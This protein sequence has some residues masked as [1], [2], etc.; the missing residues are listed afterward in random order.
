MKRNLISSLFSGL[1]LAA[2]PAGAAV[3]NITAVDL[4]GCDVLTISSIP[5]ADELGDPI[6]GFPVGERISH[7][8]STV[9]ITV[10]FDPAGMGNNP[11]IN[12]R[13][14]TITNLEA[15]SFADVYYVINGGF[16]PGTFGNFDGLVNG[17]QAMKID[18]VG[19]NR[20]LIS[21]SGNAD[22]IFQPGETWRFVV[23]DYQSGP[24][25][26]AFYTPG[27]VGAGDPLP[28]II[29]PEPSAAALGLLGG[30]MLLRRRRI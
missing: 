25:A 15:F 19:F 14:I 16:A 12:D 13:L 27:L 21:E 18:S 9:E 4:P 24:S 30:L 29:V 3:V 11:A 17:A 8:V 5:W 6:G 23:Q 26:E 7:S 1:V 10:C 2:S 28:S 22:G 20:P